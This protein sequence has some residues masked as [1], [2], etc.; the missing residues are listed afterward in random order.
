MFIRAEYQE[1]EGK[2]W[3]RLVIMP[4]KL[5]ETG[6][7]FCSISRSQWSCDWYNCLIN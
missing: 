7:T 2:K 1:K 5:S 4:I 3:N 6:L